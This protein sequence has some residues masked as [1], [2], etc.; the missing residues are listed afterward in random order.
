MNRV[1]P[2]SLLSLAACFEAEVPRD[3]MGNFAVSYSDNMRVYIGDELV[4]EVAAGT[5]EEIE[6]NGEAFTVSQVCGEEATACPSESW[7]REAAVDQPWGPDYELLNFVNLDLERGE[8]GQRMGGLLDATGSFEMLSGLAVAADNGCGV[9]GV[10]TVTGSF[11]ADAAAIEAGI[12]AYEW[13]GGCQVGEVTIGTSLRLE[14][15]FSAARTGEY[16][17]SSVTPEE[18]IDEAGQVVDPEDPEG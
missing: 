15:D 13:A 14:S 16:D 7:W 3:V 1:V 4:A 9:I 11:T 17:V 2:L 10:G 8:P 18:P 6:W 12:V 5:E